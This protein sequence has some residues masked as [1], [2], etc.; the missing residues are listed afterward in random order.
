MEMGRC[1]LLLGVRE[2]PVG[3]IK[4]LEEVVGL[5]RDIG[6]GAMVKS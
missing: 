1:P 2:I 4:D 3:L 6:I 5:G